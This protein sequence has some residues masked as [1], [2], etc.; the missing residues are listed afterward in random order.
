MWENLEL[1]SGPGTVV[2]QIEAVAQAPQQILVQQAQGAGSNA[3]LQDI[4]QL[5]GYPSPDAGAALRLPLLLVL[6]KS[7]PPDLA[8]RGCRG[9]QCRSPSAIA[10]MYILKGKLP[11]FTE[12][13]ADARGHKAMPWGC[14]Q[15]LASSA[16]KGPA[17]PLKAE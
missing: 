12:V 5:P 2:G 13:A 9:V 1:E 10:T 15:M 4:L 8:V 14:A 3:S 11:S 16:G 6:R 17:G 7:Q